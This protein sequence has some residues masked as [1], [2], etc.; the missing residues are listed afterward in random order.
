MQ[1]KLIKVIA[2]LLTTTILYAN[3]ATVVSY[4]ADNFLSAKALENQGTSTT[5]ENVEFDVYYDGGKHTVSADVNARETVSKSR[6]SPTRITSGSSRKALLK[7]A[8]KLQV[9]CPNSR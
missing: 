8:V 9:S 6:I 7:A 4:A 3:S 2:M 5:N 1:Q